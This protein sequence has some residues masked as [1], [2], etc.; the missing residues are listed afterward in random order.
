[1]LRNPPCSSSQLIM[2]RMSS[3]HA[4]AL[5]RTGQCLV[6]PGTRRCPPSNSMSLSGLRPSACT[7]NQRQPYCD[8][9]LDPN[10]KHGEGQ[11]RL[12]AAID[13]AQTGADDVYTGVVRL[14]EDYLVESFDVTIS[15]AVELAKAY[16]PKIPGF[17]Q[18]GRSSLEIVLVVGSFSAYSA[19]EIGYALALLRLSLRRDSPS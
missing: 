19:T 6:G 7:Q 18:W 9:S 3:I 16:V 14:K 8:G 10:G 1:M 4:R 15:N 13:L 5:N 11:H 2:R 17:G 12:A